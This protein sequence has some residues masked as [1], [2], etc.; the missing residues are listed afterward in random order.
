MPIDKTS[1]EWVIMRYFREKYADFPKGKLVKNESPDFILKINRRKSI[2]IELTRLDYLLDDTTKTNELNDLIN[3]LVAQKEEKLP[4]YQKNILS[5]YWLIISV[6]SLKT[7][8]KE[9]FILNSKFDKVFL[10]D[11]FSGLFIASER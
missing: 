2:G 4:L 3:K 7:V 8:L 9:Q 1:E 10:F 5:E 11:L 6:D